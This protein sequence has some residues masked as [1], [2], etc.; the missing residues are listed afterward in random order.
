MNFKACKEAVEILAEECDYSESEV[1]DL[2]TSILFDEE[3]AYRL[4]EMS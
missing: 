4:K 2:L 1:I 3:E